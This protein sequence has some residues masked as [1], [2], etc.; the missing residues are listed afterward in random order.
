MCG[1]S[2]FAR[3]L[4]DALEAAGRTTIIINEEYLHQNKRTMYQGIEYD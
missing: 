2:A 3:Q 4:A 1:K